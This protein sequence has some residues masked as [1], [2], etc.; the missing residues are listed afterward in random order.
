M[1]SNTFDKKLYEIM[2]SGKTVREMLEMLEQLRR[3][4]NYDEL[5]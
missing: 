4:R 3:E 5:H 2:T 1:D